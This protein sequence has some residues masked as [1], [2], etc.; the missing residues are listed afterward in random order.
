MMIR[1]K[2]FNQVNKLL[3]VDI[4]PGYDMLLFSKNQNAG[5]LSQIG[6]IWKYLTTRIF[7]HMKHYF[8]FLNGNDNNLT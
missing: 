5:T 3:Q 7:F 4:L 1:I 6:F 8:N 2:R